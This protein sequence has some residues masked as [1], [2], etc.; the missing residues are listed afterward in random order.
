MNTGAAFLVVLAV[1]SACVGIMLLVRRAAPRGGFF[2]DSDRAAG[3]FGVIG[4]SF[5]VLLHS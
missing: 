3:V 2:T 1:A 4:T 5:A